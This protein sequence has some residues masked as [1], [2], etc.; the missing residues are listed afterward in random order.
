M[1]SKKTQYAFKALMY[2][3]EH[4]KEKPVL[5]SEISKKKKIRSN[6]LKIFCWSFDMMVSLTVRRERA[7]D[8][9]SACPP[10]KVPLAKVYVYWM[11]RLLCSLV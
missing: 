5:I 4:S 6:S 3:A 8:I 7:A 1:L 2:L 9:F 10:K 11:G